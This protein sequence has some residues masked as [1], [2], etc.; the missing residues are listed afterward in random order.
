MA[1]KK[2]DEFGMRVVPTQY[3]ACRT[4][5]HAWDFTTVD[6]LKGEGY[7]QGLRC[8]RCKTERT[9]I[10]SLGTGL[11]GHN[12]YKYP[13]QLYDN[14]TPYQMPKGS[15]GALSMEERGIC[16]LEEIEARYKGLTDEVAVA[17][18]R[19]GSR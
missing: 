2:P 6:K 9:I 5:G 14:A 19:R 12:S 4:W 18:K 10:I 1:A 3:A 16:A 11:R 15:G 8:V 13:E 7:R 17:R